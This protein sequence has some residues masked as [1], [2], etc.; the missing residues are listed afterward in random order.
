MGDG[1]TQIRQEV[2]ISTV[3]VSGFGV[4]GCIVDVSKKEKK[5][6]LWGWQNREIP[7]WWE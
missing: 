6:P 4:V 7:S 3:S 1:V 2:N 5:P